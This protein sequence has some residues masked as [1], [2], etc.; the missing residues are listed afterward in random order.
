MIRLRKLTKT[1]DTRRVLRGI[2]LHVEPGE[3]V[4]LTGPSGAGKSTLLRLLYAVE[5]PSEGGVVAAY[6]V[7][8]A[9]SEGGEWKDVCICFE[10]MA[11]L[12]GQE[13]GADLV[14]R[15]IA[16]NRIGKGLASNT[17]TAF[18]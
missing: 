2:D 6:H 18:L 1:Y 3:F 10:T 12:T 5:K 9:R 17:V 8:V 16:V 13:R 4:F 11:V 14:Y 15:V 7:Q